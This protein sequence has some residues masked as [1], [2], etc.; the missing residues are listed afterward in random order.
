MIISMIAA[1]TDD[2]IIGIENRLPWKLPVDMRWFRRHT[3][4]KPVVMGRTTFDSLGRK[5]LPDR[6]NIVVTRDPNFSAAGVA[7]AHTL[8]EALHAAGDVPEVMIIGGASLYREALARAQRLYITF[9]HAKIIGDASFPAWQR[10][11]WR[12]IER[13]ETAPDE[14]NAYACS[15]VLLQRPNFA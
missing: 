3:V 13:T 9:V 5:P 15:F 8:D 6:H 1:M 7:V 10:D 4:G 12:E 2:G 14:K 11:E